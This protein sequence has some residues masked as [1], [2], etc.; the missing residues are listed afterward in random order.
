VQRRFSSSAALGFGCER[1][2][3]G[4]KSLADIGM[5]FPMPAHGQAAGSGSAVESAQR[6]GPAGAADLSAQCHLATP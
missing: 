1:T 5:M 4:R 6:G 2:D 3:F